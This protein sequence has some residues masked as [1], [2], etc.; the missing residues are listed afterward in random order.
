MRSILTLTMNPALDVTTSTRHL[1]PRRKLRCGEVR[2]EPGGGGVNVSRVVRE[3]GGDSTALVAAGGPT[4]D[5]LCERLQ[6]AGVETR[7]LPFEGITRQ[8]VQVFVEA[9]G[10]QYRFVPAGPEQP[11]AVARDAL[12]RLRECL[13]TGSFD[14]LVASGSLP[15]GIPA[16]FYADA[17]R[18]ANDAGVRFVLDASGESLRLALDAGLFLLA[19]NRN[20][21]AQLAGG[22]DASPERVGRRVVESGKAEAIVTTLGADGA[23]LTTRDAQTGFRAPRVE[24]K[25]TAGAGDSFVAGLVYALAD[26]RTV[27]DA[28]CYGIATAA[29]AVT[30]EATELAK[31]ADVEALRSEVTAAAL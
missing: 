29:A 30:T 6:A 11:P 7:R 5:L 18:A 31:A 28:C 8:S 25:S 20:E 9:E 27:A 24:V 23:L 10:A 16:T 14:Y 4:G 15:P 19:P 13:G 21:T 26:G 17:A 1:E 22:D 3:L 2:Y 12:E